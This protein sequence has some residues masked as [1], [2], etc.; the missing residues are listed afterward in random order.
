VFVNLI[1]IRYLIAA[2]SGLAFVAAIAVVASAVVGREIKS[3]SRFAFGH[4]YHWV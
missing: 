1:L 4:I 3:G 2:M